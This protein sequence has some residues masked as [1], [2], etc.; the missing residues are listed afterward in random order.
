MLFG[1]HLLASEDPLND[2]LLIDD[3]GGAN[4]S[5]GLLA[6]H[7]LLTPGAHRLQQFMVDVGNQGEG[8]LVFVLELHV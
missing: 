4:S 8:Q 7:I 2:T 1:F 5:H 3:K 6:V